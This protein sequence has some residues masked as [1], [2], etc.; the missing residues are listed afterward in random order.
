MADRSESVTNGRRSELPLDARLSLILIREIIANHY[1]PG[2][3]L[4]E[5]EIAARHG[6]SRASVREALRNVAYAGF[7]EI[8]PWRG[9][10]VAEV[11]RSELLDIFSLLEETYGR[12]AYWAAERCPESAFARLDELMAHLEDAVGRGLSQAE[13]DTRSFAIGQFVGANSGSDLAY[14]MLVQVGNLAIWQQRLL[15]EGGPHVEEQSR[16]A[17]HLLVS[18]IKARE[19]EIAEASARM[20]VMITRRQLEAAAA[21]GVTRAKLNNK[22]KPDAKP[23]D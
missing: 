5:Q 11:S 12:C 3:R 4:R 1:P 23:V 2:S 10:K 17:H 21:P 22:R 8:E 9:A 20:I 13:K 15:L 18:A 19:P 16:A 6:V 7:V 14:R